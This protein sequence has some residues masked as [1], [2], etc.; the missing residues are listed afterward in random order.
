VHTGW[1]HNPLST[2]WQWEN[3]WLRWKWGHSLPV[4][5]VNS[6]SYPTTINT[7]TFLKLP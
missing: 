3:L 7:T 1:T 2:R 4:K 5:V 6:L